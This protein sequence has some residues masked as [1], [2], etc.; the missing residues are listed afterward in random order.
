MA[1]VGLNF[2]SATS[3][4]GFD[5]TSTVTSIMANL[6]AP[7]T[8]WA[9]QANTLAAQ[10]AVLS[11]L[12]TDMSALAAALSTLTSFDGAFSQKSGAVSDNT[13]VALTNATMD[14]SAGDHTLTV[15]KLATTSQQHSTLL[16]KGGALS[17]NLTL[18]IGDGNPVT[19]T[20]DE[21]NNTV[22]GLAAA[23]NNRNAGVTATIITDSMGVRLSLTGPSGAANELRLDTSSLV[24]AEGNSVNMTETQ[25]AGDASFTLD[26]VPL[27]S[28]TNSISEALTGVTFQLLGV[29][30]RA[31]TMQIANDTSG[32]AATLGSFVSAYNTLA[33]ALSEQE[34][35]NARG[36]G[37]PLYGDQVL[38]LLQS[39]LS[40]A[41]AFDTS[42]SDASS[43]LT[44]L[45]ITI[46]TDGQMTLETSTLS[47]ELADN[48]G[49][50]ATFFQVAG[51]FGQ[52]LTSVLNSLGVRGNGVLALRSA[53]NTSQESM[54]AENKTR[55]EARLATYEANLTTELNA[56]NEI[57]Q[58]IPS[59]LNELKE[60]YAAI[61]GYKGD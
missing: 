28:D 55:L 41:L 30:S 49:G 22:V 9:T 3:G 20:V 35:K 15:Q 5:V 57:L 43:D 14:A 23:I 38:S 4:T 29:T 24:D 12:G 34:V 32:I 50:A 17:G 44:R 37:E 25:T 61:T 16:P 58:S 39:Q 6:R 21:S 10:D 8:A 11:A 53:Q 1:V 18:Q 40:A 54:L 27:T 56:A 59:R 2:G 45:G 36:N 33:S 51:G 31:V 48:F 19:I 42:T 47:A 13:L 7:E 26:G 60:I 52:N 46:G